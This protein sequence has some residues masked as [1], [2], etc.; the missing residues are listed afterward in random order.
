H[1]FNVCLSW[2]AVLDA[3]TKIDLFLAR[4]NY[5]ARS[6]QLVDSQ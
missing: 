4:G 5:S 6:T 3:L 1:A 2:A